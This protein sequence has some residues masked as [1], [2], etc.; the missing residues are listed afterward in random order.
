LYGTQK[1]WVRRFTQFPIEDTET[2]QPWLTLRDRKK[3]LGK[4]LPEN[5]RRWMRDDATARAYRPVLEEVG[6]L[7]TGELARQ[8]SDMLV[9]DFLVGNWDRFSTSRAYWGVNCQIGEGKL[10]SID[11]GAAFPITAAAKVE[12]NFMRTERFNP[13][14]IQALRDLDQDQA[15]A[16]LFPDA[17]PQDIKRFELFWQQ[18]ARVLARVDG[19]VAKHGAEAVLRFDA[20][21]P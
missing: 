1:D 15:R 16:W 3:T 6:E 5:L 14:L 10:I 11:N 4:P 21:A 12:A 18:R 8:L 13:A 17:S 2:W 7:A 19:L 9:F 20:P